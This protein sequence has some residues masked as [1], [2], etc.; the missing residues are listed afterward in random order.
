MK[1]KQFEL[2]SDYIFALTFANDELIETD[3]APLLAQHVAS[4]E[5]TSARI[6]QDWGCLEFK[7]GAVDIEPHTLY[8]WA[9]SHNLCHH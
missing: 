2:R 3:L 8:Q 1:L 4:G 9:E 7:D 6:D 5:L